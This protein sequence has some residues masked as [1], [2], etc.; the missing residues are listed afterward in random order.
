MTSKT[1]IK[2]MKFNKEYANRVKSSGCVLCRNLGEDRLDMHHVYP[3]YK[4]FIISRGYT[5]PVR[6]F[7]REMDKC[8]CLCIKCHNDVHNPPGFIHPR[9][10]DRDLYKMLIE[11]AKTDG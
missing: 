5:F 10:L 11:G 9:I 4:S 6:D 1:E 8:I 7:L 3:K 2:N